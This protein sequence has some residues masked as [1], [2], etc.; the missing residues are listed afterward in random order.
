MPLTL[1]PA[2]SDESDS[3]SQTSQE[4]ALL[5]DHSSGRSRWPPR[6]VT[7]CAIQLEIADGSPDVDIH[8]NRGKSLEDV[9]HSLSLTPA[10]AAKDP[11]G[12]M[13]GRRRSRGRR[14]P[15]EVT[16]TTFQRGKPDG[17]EADEDEAAQPSVTSVSSSNVDQ[18][19][20]K[21]K[22]NSGATSKEST[23]SSSARTDENSLNFVSGNPF[24][25]VMFN[26]ISY[27]IYTYNNFVSSALRKCVT[28]ASQ[29]NHDFCQVTKGVIHLY[30]E[31][32][33]TSLEEGVIRSQ[34][35]CELSKM[36]T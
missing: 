29:F 18:T 1:E 7:F 25:E 2:A 4:A 12:V 32:Q 35:L 33:A 9:F 20:E 8:F 23:P 17:A 22:S 13:S 31:N 27:I 30:K 11:E 19:G 34:M 14:T 36:Q 28:V 16:V 3:A 24:V 21:S 6:C 26:V 10:L 15:A 5:P